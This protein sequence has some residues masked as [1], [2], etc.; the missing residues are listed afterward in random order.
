MAAALAGGAGAGGGA[1]GLR[2]PSSAVVSSRLSSTDQMLQN[3]SQSVVISPSIALFQIQPS[4]RAIV[5]VAVN[6]AI[7]E[8]IAAVVERSVTISCVT[9]RE[10]VLKDFA[11]ES[12]PSLVRRAA[13]L[14]VASLAGTLALVT[15]REPLRVSLTTSLRGL[16]Q[17]ATNK[18]GN[19]ENLLEQVVQIL[20]GDN[21]EVGCSLIEQAVVEKALRDIEDTMRPAFQA[22]ARAQE[23]KLAFADPHLIQ[24]NN[25]W[26]LQNM[27]ESL[28]IRKVL[29]NRQ[30]QVY[31][32]FMNLGPLK[33]MHDHRP[34]PSSGGRV[35]SGVA[36]GGGLPL[37]GVSSTGG[38]RGGGRGAGGSSAGDR[39]SV[40]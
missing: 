17:P 33:R 40:V 37:G 28:R 35:G 10:V 19:D 15:C 18:Q 34:Q 25:P 1:G 14:M 13:H 38:D 39:K 9:T 11:L 26:P 6:R 30:L 27:P 23:E 24:P 29:T 22:R 36:G 12:D 21:I 7:R 16:L 20:A 5:P 4:L 2:A 31:K 32:D 3:L 8:I